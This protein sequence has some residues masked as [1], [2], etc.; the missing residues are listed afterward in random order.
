[1][2]PTRPSALAAFGMAFFCCVGHS[3]DEESQITV[4]NLADHTVGLRYVWSVPRSSLNALP[5]WNP[6]TA[7]VPLSPHKAAATATEFLRT[8]FPSSAHLSIFSISL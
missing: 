3:A 1:M 6:L 2:M 5:R 7:E 4:T 8:R